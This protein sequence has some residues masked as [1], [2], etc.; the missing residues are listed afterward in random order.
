MTVN[1][2]KETQKQYKLNPIKGEAIGRQNTENKEQ[3]T[4][5]SNRN[6]LPKGNGAIFQAITETKIRKL[7]T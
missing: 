7:L 1:T 5:R 4:L 3:V 2:N 6:G